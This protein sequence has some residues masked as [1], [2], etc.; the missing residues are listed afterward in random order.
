MQRQISEGNMYNDHQHRVY[1]QKTSRCMQPQISTFKQLLKQMCRMLLKILILGNR[2]VRTLQ[3]YPRS[4]RK[5]LQLLLHLWG[6]YS[7][8]VLLRASGLLCGKWGNGHL[9]S[10]RETNMQA[11]ENYRPITVHPLLGKVF[12][13]LL[14]KQITTYYD[15]ILHSRMTAYR[16]QSSCAL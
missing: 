7:I 2:L 14:C 8:T 11:K 9:Y 16:K 13:H 10:K 1:K 6:P 12:E 5:L 4:L 3:L 15:R